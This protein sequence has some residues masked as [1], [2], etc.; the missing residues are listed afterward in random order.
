MLSVVLVDWKTRDL[1]RASLASLFRYPTDEPTQ[2]IVV[3]NDPQGGAASSARSEF[4]DVIVVEPGTNT[5]YARGNNLGFAQARGDWILTLNPDTEVFE[6]TLDAAIAC[7]KRW[8]TAGAVGARLV[9]PGGETQ[10]SVRGFPT[11]ANLLSEAVGLGR[12]LPGTRFDAYRLRRF[13]YETEGPAPQPMGTFLIYR[14]A[15]LVQVGDPSAPFDESFPIFF[16]EVDLLHRLAQ[17]GW[18]AVYCPDARVLH[19]HGSSTKQVRPAMTWE[20]QQSLVRYL[21]KHYGR[22]VSAPLIPLVA[23]TAWCS[24]LARSRCLP[25]RWPLG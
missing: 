23:A 4:P 3:D 11:P 25:R 24:A 8:P 7:L 22:S 21:A 12:A 6:G 2:V 16:N 10:R 13:D 19:H 15:A 14:R 20:S 1:L 17:V 9:L 18:H 5:G